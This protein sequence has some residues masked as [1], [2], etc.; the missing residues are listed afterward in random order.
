MI[1]PTLRRLRILQ[2]A[3][4][5]SVAVI[6]LDIVLGYGS[7]L[8]PGGALVGAIEEARRG[9]G[10]KGGE[11]VVMAHICG[12]EADPQS[13]NEQSKRLSKAGVVLFASNAQM[14]VASALVVGGARASTQLKKK[15]SELLGE[16]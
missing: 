5:P 13:L 12:T 2:E 14:A 1:D 8:D 16:S 7:S 10:R 11:L 3:K 9:A 4:D 15:W 6:M